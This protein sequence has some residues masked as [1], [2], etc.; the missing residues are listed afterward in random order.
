MLELEGAVYSWTCQKLYDGTWTKLYESA[1]EAAQTPSAAA[2]AEQAQV[3]S[4]CLGP[5]MGILHQGKVND[6]WHRLVSKRNQ[7]NTQ[8]NSKKNN[9]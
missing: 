7:Q 5:W 9:I 2:E 4:V 8:N 3:K 1:G 6:G